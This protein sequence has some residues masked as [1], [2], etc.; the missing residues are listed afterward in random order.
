MIAKATPKGKSF[1]GIVNYLFKGRLENRGKVEKHARVLCSSSNLEIPYNHDDEEG[2]QRLIDDFSNQAKLHS[3]FE[4]DKAYVG[5][6]IISF[7]QDDMRLLNE[8]QKQ[9]IIQQ[10]VRDA[11]LDATQY[12]AVSHEDTDDFHV[13]VVFNRCMNNLKIYDDWKEKKKAAEKAVALNLKYD[14][15]LSGKQHEL[16]K[17]SGVW[18][19]R[20]QHEDIQELA[21]DPLLKDIR[22]M[23]HLKKVCETTNKKITEDEKTI[24][25]EGKSYRKVDLEA[26]FF[27]NRRDKIKEKGFTAKKV[28]YKAPP[29]DKSKDTPGYQLKQQKYILQQ[30]EGE[31]QKK[32]TRRQETQESSSSSVN[33]TDQENNQSFNYKKSWLTEEDEFLSK[34]R[35]RRF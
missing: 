7:S 20:M 14:L 9:E 22:N 23:H 1:H 33:L 3:D 19:F 35:R 32:P 27:K 5:H 6:H 24:K 26:V 10:Y 17:S 34:K 16:A 29:K 15:P 30:E 25:V 21:K 31:S 13:H 2:I 8:E 12:I 28:T 11:G 18:E 4:Y